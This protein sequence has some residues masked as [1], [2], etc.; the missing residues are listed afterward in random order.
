MKRI[1]CFLTFLILSP[2]VVNAEPASEELIRELLVVTEARKVV[3]SLHS[4]VGRTLRDV[5]QRSLKGKVLSPAEQ[6]RVEEMNGK[7]LALLRSEL[8][9]EK[10][11]MMHLRVYQELF[12]EEEITGMI[13]FY[14]TPA[15]QAFVKKQPELLRRLLLETQTLQRELQPKLLKMALTPV[16][17]GIQEKAVTNP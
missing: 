2:T 17:Q 15:G 5:V 12:S 3:D 16:D 8:S 4:Q 7:M 11:E 1:I 13:N 9:W 10:L 14:R 6:E